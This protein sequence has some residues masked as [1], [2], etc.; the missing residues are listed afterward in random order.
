MYLKSSS[1]T[2]NSDVKH[3]T[4]LRY[5]SN[6][7]WFKHWCFSKIS[8]PNPIGPVTIFS[9]I[10]A[11]ARPN[12]VTHFRPHHYFRFASSAQTTLITNWDPQGSPRILSR[13]REPFGT[14]LQEI[15]F[16]VYYL[17]PTKILALVAIQKYYLLIQHHIETVIYSYNVVVIKIL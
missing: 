12:M 13:F 4:V 11:A 3:I 6:R 1:K 16:R 10:V 7:S 15:R 17:R 5:S 8:N 2:Q 9:H 14:E